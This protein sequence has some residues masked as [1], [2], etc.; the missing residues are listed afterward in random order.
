[1]WSVKVIPKAFQYLYDLSDITCYTVT[2]M[3]NG[4]TGKV[5][6]YGILWQIITVNIWRDT[7]SDEG[8]VG[9]KTEV[10]FWILRSQEVFP[11]NLYICDR[12]CEYIFSYDKEAKRLIWNRKKF[13]SLYDTE[14]YS[15]DDLTAKPTKT[16]ITG[17]SNRTARNL[18]LHGKRQSA[19]P[20]MRST[21]GQE[22]LIHT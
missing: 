18:C 8:T 16:S 5:L 4:S 6:I 2:G 13:H 14:T 10:C 9:E 20:D 22:P 3:M 1:M 17:I 15:A 11:G 19:N 21:A 7:N 12:Q